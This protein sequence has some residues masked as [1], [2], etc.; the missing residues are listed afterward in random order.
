[1][2]RPAAEK[3]LDELQD[4]EGLLVRQAPPQSPCRKAGIRQCERRVQGNR[5]HLQSALWCYG[6]QE[7]L[8]SLRVVR[9]QQPNGRNSSH[10]V[11]S[12]RD[13]A[14]ELTVSKYAVEV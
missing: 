10:H 1:M 9:M 14:D 6:C 13:K 2:A 11:G 7:S 4:R 12:G 3:E 5:E 8:S